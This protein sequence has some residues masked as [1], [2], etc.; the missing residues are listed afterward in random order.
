M[1]QLG[2]NIVQVTPLCPRN[3][4]CVWFNHVFLNISPILELVTVHC[5]VNRLKILDDKLAGMKLTA[6]CRRRAAP[7]A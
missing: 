2:Y 5:I 7:G 1:H 6:D 4:R 3:L